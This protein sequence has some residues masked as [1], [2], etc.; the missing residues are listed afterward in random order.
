MRRIYK[1]PAGE[2]LIR[3]W[4][5]RFH[6]RLPFATETRQVTTSAGPTQV[7][8]TGPDNGTPIV[9]L[10][11]A[12]AGA[13]HALGEMGMFPDQH[14]IY[15]VD[16]PGQSVASAHV[17]LPV[18][19]D[20][21]GRWLNEVMAALDLPQALIIGVSWGGFVALNLTRYFPQRVAGLILL[22]PAGLVNGDLWQ[23]FKH[24]SWPMM[25]YQMAPSE[26]RRDAMLRGLNTSSD[27]LWDGYLGDALRHI[28]TQFSLPP[29]LQPEHVKHFKAPVYIFA[30]GNDRCFPGAHLLTRAEQVFPNLIGTHLFADY[31]HCPPFGDEFG[32]PWARQLETLL[33]SKFLFEPLT[34]R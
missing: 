24:I 13:A 10:H 16:I 26:A 17:R 12:L 9:L 11:G 4:Y 32:I 31:G 19:G 18:K 15:A 7:L 27:P 1:T 2:A 3:Q 23:G 34:S 6:A 25:R 5:E 21:H 28:T 20:A 30:S 22:N 8:V 29:L 14:R 33:Q